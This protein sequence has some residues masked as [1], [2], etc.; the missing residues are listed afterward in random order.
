M[1]IPLKQKAYA[2]VL[3]RIMTGSFKPG[4]KL[5][6]VAMAK[7]IGISPTP[8]R[9]AYRQLASEGFVKYVPNSGIFV[10]EISEAE[11]AEL[12]ETREALEPFCARLAAIKMN[13]IMIEELGHCL[14]EM[15]ALARELQGSGAEAFSPEQELRYL[16][17]DAKF[18]LLILKAAGNRIIFKTMRECHVLERLIGLKSHKHTLRQVALTRR[19]HS[20]IFKYIRK[21]DSAMAEDWM[22]KHI[23]F[24]RAT[25]LQNS[26]SCNDPSAEEEYSNFREFI[27]EK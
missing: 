11:L 17:S 1:K 10:R 6:E 25:S 4:A 21:H 13:L 24:S 19:Q 18:H 14:S 3:N 15:L 5:S 8:L 23:A 26:P 22:R 7:E 2:H 16:K 20:K 12:Y 27:D 9:E